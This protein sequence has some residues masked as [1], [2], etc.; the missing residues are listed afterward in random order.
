VFKKKKNTKNVSQ[1]SSNKYIN[2]DNL[3]SKL[4]TS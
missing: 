2:N 4:S 1:T 3:A